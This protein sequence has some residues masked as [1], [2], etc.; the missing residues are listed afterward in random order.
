[1]LQAKNTKMAGF[2]FEAR[3]LRGSLPASLL[4]EVPDVVDL[5]RLQHTSRASE[6]SPRTNTTREHR[7]S[8]Q[9]SPKPQPAEVNTHST[10]AQQGGNDFRTLSCT[11]HTQARHLRQH[12]YHVYLF[13]LCTAKCTRTHTLPSLG[14]GL[15][16]GS[17]IGRHTPV[18]LAAFDTLTAP[19]FAKGLVVDQEADRTRDF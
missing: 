11:Q 12:T 8:S 10:Q 9:A 4:Q 18:V 19:T 17:K 14:G 6:S 1:M 13:L 2:E 15:L 16:F 7:A 5:L 3:L